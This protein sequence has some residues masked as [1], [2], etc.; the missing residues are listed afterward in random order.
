MDDKRLIFLASLF[1]LMVGLLIPNGLAGVSRVLSLDGG[2]D[3]VEVIDS[4][5]LTPQHITIESWIMPTDITSTHS[6]VEKYDWVE[7]KGTYA[8]RQEGDGIK[9]YL[10]WGRNP[11]SPSAWTG[12]TLSVGKWQHVAGVYD[13]V[14]I[15]IY[16]NGR[17]EATSTI[18]KG[19]LV[20][21]DGSLS[22]GSRGDTHDVYGFNGLIDEV[23][24]WSVAHTQQEIQ[25]TMSTTLTGNEAGLVGYWNF[26][27]GTANDLSPNGNHGTL[28]G[29]VAIVD[30][31][32]ATVTVDIKVVPNP[33][34]VGDPLD[35]LLDLDNRGSGFNAIPA[36]GISGENL[37]LNIKYI[38]RGYC[39]AGSQ[40]N[41][42]DLGGF[43]PSKNMPV[44]FPS[45]YIPKKKSTE[46][47]AF[48]NEKANFGKNYEG[49]K[50]VLANPTDKDVKMSA[51]DSRLSIVMQAKIEG[52][53]WR[54]IEYLPSSWCG[55]SYH[56]VTLPANKSW[57]FIAPIYNG[58]IKAK[59]RFVLGKITSNEFEGSINK[60]QFTIKQGHKPTG[61]MDPYNE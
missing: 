14:E 22:I 3:W 28:I 18:E 2:G 58:K 59:L 44:N 24:V 49:F 53:K 48:P 17:L 41:P 39:Y 4:P 20:D 6:I 47:I 51:S 36:L 11:P 31:S 19:D 35:I 55:N 32:I 57:V 21:G 38:L 1:I 61:I 12:S 10:V 42:G 23:R 54:N 27:D 40:P 56:T 37:K 46:L 13:G 50:L 52:E 25:A 26:D 60:E 45:F 7:G 9:F 33:A 43:W 29:D 30:T 34:V 5:T 15:R 16:I 8:L